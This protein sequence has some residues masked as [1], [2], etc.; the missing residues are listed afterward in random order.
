MKHLEQKAHRWAKILGNLPGVRAIF[1]SGSVAAGTAKK[2]ADIDFLVIAKSGQL[3]TARFFI[4]FVLKIFSQLAK[5]H[6][7]ARKICP[8]HF[9]ADHALEIN[10][11]DAYAAHLFAHNK[12]LYDP[13]G[14][15]K[16]FVAEN[17]KWVQTFGEDFGRSALH[18]PGKNPWKRANPQSVT[19]NMLETLL[20]K[21]QRWK[22]EKN[23]D[24]K[25][26]G[27]KIV[28]NDDE[29]RFHPEPK[30]K[31]WKKPA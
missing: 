18:P 12:P 7:H 22:I 28:L 1:L 10:E 24:F 20:E 3:W 30:N 31:T 27:A 29:L 5:P 11:K 23:P 25:K 26:P 19:K 2:N 9:I 21:T 13:K 16:F 6:R 4:F 17:E 14:V 8:N 15:W